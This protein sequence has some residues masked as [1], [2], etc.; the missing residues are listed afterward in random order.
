MS[1]FPFVSNRS[2]NHRRRTSK[3]YQG[4]PVVCW[5]LQG[6]WFHIQRK[7]GTNTSNIWSRQRNCYTIC[8][9]NFGADFFKIV[10]DIFSGDSLASYLSVICTDEVPW[11]SIDLMKQDR[12]TP[13]DILQKNWQM[14]IAQMILYSWQLPLRRTNVC[15]IACDKQQ[16][17]LVFIRSVIK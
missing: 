14:L 7:Y 2:S 10:S 4:N 11:T 5:F 6:V 3:K 15:C 9:L 12:L 1:F 13:N 8:S 17:V 16:E